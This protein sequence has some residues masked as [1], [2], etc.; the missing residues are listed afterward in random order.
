M[1]HDT[2]W[3]APD[4]IELIFYYPFCGGCWWRG[5]N[6]GRG[7]SPGPFPTLSSSFLIVLCLW[8]GALGGAFGCFVL[9]EVPWLS[10]LLFLLTPCFSP[11]TQ[12]MGG[13]LLTVSLV[14]IAWGTSGVHTQSWLI[15]SSHTG[16]YSYDF[17]S[18]C[19]LLETLSKSNLCLQAHFKFCFPH[20]AIPVHPRPMLRLNQTYTVYLLVYSH[21]TLLTSYSSHFLALFKRKKMWLQTESETHKTL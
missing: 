7:M 19:V 16:A 18:S 10:I 2:T 17:V 4:Q 1:W 20:E 8:L 11:F 9:S 6:T 15:V 3:V 21:M 13:N 5:G 14:D 12:A